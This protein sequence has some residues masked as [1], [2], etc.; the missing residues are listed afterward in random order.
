MW[1]YLFVKGMFSLIGILAIS[2][3]GCGTD[4]EDI[5]EET[6]EDT[7]PVPIGMVLIPE[8]AFEMGS[9]ADTANIDERLST[10]ST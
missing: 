4:T 9:T 2:M 6:P 7:V 3:L 10:P 5:V 8:G 1:K